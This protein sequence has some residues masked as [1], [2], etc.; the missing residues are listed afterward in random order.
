M[1]QRSAGE[2][3]EVGC[4]RLCS[5]FELLEETFDSTPIPMSD[6]LELEVLAM[7]GHMQPGCSID[8]NDRVGNDMFLLEFSEGR[9]GQRLVLG[10]K[11]RRCSLRFVSGLTAVDSQ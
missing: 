7:A 4:E 11:S 10:G 8:Q 5:V 9:L 3:S 2:R 1:F 6:M